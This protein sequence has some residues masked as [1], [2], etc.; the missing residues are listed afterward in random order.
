MNL[1]YHMGVSHLCVL[2]GING[3]LFTHV[4]CTGTSLCAFHSS[5]LHI[6]VRITVYL[7]RT[8]NSDIVHVMLNESY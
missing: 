1:R 5:K 8:P 2:R 7:V 6:T 4:L 3:N